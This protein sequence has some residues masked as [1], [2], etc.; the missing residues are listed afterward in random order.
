M[1]T[2]VLRKLVDYVK[3]KISP[4]IVVLSTLENEKI[5][6]IVG[7]SKD[8]SKKYRA[9]SIVSEIAPHIEGKGGGRDDLAQAGGTK[10]EGINE[11]IENFETIL[12]KLYWS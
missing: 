5:H 2:K 3:S 9:S 4:V 12:K 1:D 10:T 7:V 6:L 11:I 8:L